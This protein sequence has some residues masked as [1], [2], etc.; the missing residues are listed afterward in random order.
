MPGPTS[1]QG[2]LGVRGHHVWTPSAGSPITL[3]DQT[4]LTDFPLYVLEYPIR[5]LW[6]G[7]DGDD[8][9]ELTPEGIGEIPLASFARGKTIT[10]TGFIF[11]ETEEEMRE[12]GQAL[13]TAF[14]PDL[15]TGQYTV[16]RMVIQSSSGYSEVDPDDNVYHTFTAICRDWDIDE[17][18]PPSPSFQPSPHFSHFVIDLR[19]HDPRIFAWDPG[20]SPGSEVGSA[21]W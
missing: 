3:N 5:G 9:R 10:Y 19:L 7:P 16:G 20:A 2:A 1:A 21:K 12:A 13:R 11:G 17:A 8:N 18:A 14:G 15:T 4:D 6:S